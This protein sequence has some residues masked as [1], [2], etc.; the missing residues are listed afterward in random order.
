MG[1]KCLA[2]FL[3]QIDP[4]QYDGPWFQR[5]CAGKYFGPNPRYEL[6]LPSV[7]HQFR[8]LEPGRRQA[9]YDS[10]GSTV[11][12]AGRFLLVWNGDPLVLQCNLSTVRLRVSGSSA[13]GPSQL[14]LHQRYLSRCNY[15]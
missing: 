11:L 5:T 15:G 2:D 3:S 8:W 12:G 7:G 10:L 6:P 9:L 1:A 4:D 13:P 14:D